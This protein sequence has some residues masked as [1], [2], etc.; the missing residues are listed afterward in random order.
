[1]QGAQLRVWNG[2]A[3]GSV[4][5]HVCVGDDAR[6]P[7]RLALALEEGGEEAG[8]LI[9]QGLVDRLLVLAAEL[10]EV[11]DLQRRVLPACFE[12]VVRPQRLGDGEEVVGPAVLDQ[13]GAL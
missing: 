10:A 6:V 13:H 1:M 2:A 5:G 8:A 11:A 7:R 4:E 12:R 9:L 3:G